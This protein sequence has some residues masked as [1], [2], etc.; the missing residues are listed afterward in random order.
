MARKKQKILTIPTFTHEPTN[1]PNIFRFCDLNGDW[2][3]YWMKEENVYLPA[4]NHVLGIGYP[5]DKR[6][7]EY[8]LSVTKEEAKKKL[9]MKGEAGARTHDAIQ[10]LIGG[11]RIDIG[12]KFLN[13]TTGK[14]EIL[15][16]D[17][18]WNLQSWMAWAAKYKPGK[19]AYEFALADTTVGMAGTSDFLGTVT[20]P[21]DD[22]RMPKELWGKT[23]AILLDWKSSG[24]IYDEYRLQTSIYYMLCARHPKLGK[25]FKANQV[26]TGI[27]RVGTS[28]KEGYEFEIYTPDETQKH[29]ELARCAKQVYDSKNGK[30]F[31]AEIVEI[32]A[33]FKI[34][35]PLV[36]IT[37]NVNDNT[38]RKS[39]ARV[40]EQVD[41]SADGDNQTKVDLL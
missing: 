37:K 17:E 36:A 38:K 10:E 33:E 31:A 30:P 21:Q 7:H 5:K 41:L 2:T 25:F 16:N 23:I 22:K 20:I 29:F 34:R 35:M 39:T 8:L 32:P 24:A 6:F 9:E 15:T 18:W 3:H 14:Q 11:R 27:V 4:V 28:H 13:R 40:P 19:L 1:D 26:Y 12:T